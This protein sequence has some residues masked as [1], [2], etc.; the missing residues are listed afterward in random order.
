MKTTNNIA[1]AAMT[2]CIIELISA[3]SGTN[4]I[5]AF[6]SE[7]YLRISTKYWV[8]TMRLMRT[9]FPGPTG[10]PDSVRAGAV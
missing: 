5:A 9:G 3:K 1:A 2:I 8:P 7:C 6:L 4:G 10:R